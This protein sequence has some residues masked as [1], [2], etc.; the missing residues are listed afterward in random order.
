MV[1]VSFESAEDL[2]AGAPRKR[3]PRKS[4]ALSTDTTTTA[5][6]T[7]VPADELHRRIAETAYYKAQQR[8]F[9]PGYEHQDWVEA[10]A[11]VMQRLK[12]ARP[13]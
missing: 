12:V 4:S 11:E 1:V 8:G 6:G 5:P 10:E 13:A 3:P 2:R 7:E 9:A